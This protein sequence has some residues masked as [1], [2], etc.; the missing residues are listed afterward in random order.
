MCQVQSF[1]ELTAKLRAGLLRVTVQEASGCLLDICCGDTDTDVAGLI[2][3]TAKGYVWQWYMW[4]KRVGEK[5]GV[6]KQGC[7]VCCRMLCWCWLAAAC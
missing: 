2:C 6:H 1:F 3:C 5:A 4:V 7:L